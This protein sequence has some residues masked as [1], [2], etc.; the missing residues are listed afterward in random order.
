MSDPVIKK[1]LYPSNSRISK[2]KKK[3]D[4]ND[5]KEQKL[6]KIVQGDVVKK[7]KTLG[8]KFKETFVADEAQS[9]G[10]YIF[11]DVIVP[12]VK[13]TIIDIVTKG[14]NMIF[15]GDTR[16]TRRSER[17]TRSTRTNYGSYYSNT[18][19]DSRDRRALDRRTRSSH[20]FDNLVYLSRGEAEEVRD[21]LVELIDTYG[22]ATVADLYDL[23]G[24]T[25]EYTDH[26][27][28]WD[29]LG[30]TR[31]R[32]ISSGYIIILPKPILLGD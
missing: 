19:L 3:P 10:N 30:T 14:I 8:D 7:K 15:Y 26:K 12:T 6:E 11:I 23:S 22:Q 25:S 17:S 28:G 13:E 16:A 32:R 1:E 21:N 18:L 29:E 31:V 24:I 9:V 27:Y 20:D 2:K 5:V 4:V